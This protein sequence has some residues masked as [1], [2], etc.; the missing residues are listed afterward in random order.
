MKHTKVGVGEAIAMRKDR[1][2]IDHRAAINYILPFP[3]N[4]QQVNPWQK[5]VDFLCLGF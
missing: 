5:N 2:N 4:L 3:G 1:K